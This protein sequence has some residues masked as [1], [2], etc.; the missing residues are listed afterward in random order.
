MGNWHTH[1]SHNIVL[2]GG[3]CICVKCGATEMSKVQNLKYAC[4][5]LV[6]LDV[7]YQQSHGEANIKRYNKGRAPLGFPD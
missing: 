1:P 6:P 3:V 5:G 7:P 4:T 2:Y